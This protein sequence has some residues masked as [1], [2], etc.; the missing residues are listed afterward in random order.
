MFG[1]YPLDNEKPLKALERQYKCYRE[2]QWSDIMLC[3]W[4]LFA[5]G[6]FTV[7]LHI[8]LAVGK[9][10]SLTWDTFCVPFLPIPAL[11]PL[12]CVLRDLDPTPRVMLSISWL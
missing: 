3:P 2:G 9:A 10:T 8:C 5:R 1:L 11:C 7:G 4:A 6:T 12:I